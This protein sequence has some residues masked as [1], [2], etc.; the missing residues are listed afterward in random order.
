LSSGRVCSYF[1]RQLR[2]TNGA[3]TAQL[4]VAPAI[5]GEGSELDSI[6]AVV[7]GGADLFGGEGGIFGTFLG[8]VIIGSL[9]NI[10][11]LTGVSPFVQ[12]LAEGALIIAAVTVK[13]RGRRQ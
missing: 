2:D 3:G 9:A 6:A 7:V 12:K 8:A 11:N 1:P 13:A 4:A 10:L 5:A